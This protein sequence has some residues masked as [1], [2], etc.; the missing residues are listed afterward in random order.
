M[1]RSEAFFGTKE[2]CLSSGLGGPNSKISKP[3][4]SAVK[5]GAKCNEKAQNVKTLYLGLGMN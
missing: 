4:P 3:L 5:S 2:K 1:A